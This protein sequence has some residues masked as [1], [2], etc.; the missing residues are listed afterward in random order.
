MLSISFPQR[1]SG[2]YNPEI[3]MTGKQRI[4]RDRWQQEQKQ[5]QADRLAR[6]KNQQGEWKREWDKEKTR[7]GLVLCRPSINEPGLSGS[8]S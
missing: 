8:Q 5:I 1:L 2:E 4:E 6:S 3:D 7:A